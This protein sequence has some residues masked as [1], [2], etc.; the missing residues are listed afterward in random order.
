V[1]QRIVA[2]TFANHNWNGG[3]VMRAKLHS[4]GPGL[5]AR[6]AWL[7]VVALALGSGAAQGQGVGTGTIT[8]RLTDET[9][10]SMPGVTITV[11]SP[12]LQMKELTDVTSSDGGYRFVDMPIGVYSVKY[13]LT[14]FQSVVR[15]DVRLTA[16]FT[17]RLDA[18]LKVGALAET[19]TV[20][21]QSPVIDTS[22]TSG[23]V[24]FT[25]ETLENAPTSRAFA[26]VL[27][28][29]PGFRPSSVD[30][31]GSELSDMRAGVRNYGT[32][33]QLTPQLEG[34]NTRQG[35]NSAGFFY[36]Y[37]AVEE[38]QIQAVGN[39]AETALPGGAWNAIVKSGGDEFHGRYS[40]SGQNSKLQ[41][42]NVDDELRN[43]GV[44]PAG[45]GMRWYRD[46]SADLGGRIIR[47]RLWFY[48]ALHDQRSEENLIGFAQATGP[49]GV[50]FTAD[51]VPGYDRTI[52]HNQTVKSTFQATQTQKFVGFYQRSQKDSP[53]GQS[54]GPF[55]PFPATYNYEFPTHATKGE[56]TGTP[57][58]RVLFNLMGGR[59]WYD[60]NR[61]PQEGEDRPGNPR[62]FDRE[63]GR[64]LGPQHIQLRPRSRWQS[65]GSVSLFPEKLL[66]G[67]HSIK[68]GYQFFWEQ[69]GTAWLNMASG[70]Y[71]L[72]FD[73]VNNVSNQPAEFEAYNTPI[74][75]PVNK[76]TQYSFFVQDKWT[77]DRVTVN[78]GVRFDRYHAF[79]GEQVKEQGPFGNAG[80]FDAVDVLTWASFAPRL[81]IAWDLR[82]DGKTVAKATYGWFNHVMTEDFAAAYN[83][84]T[85]TTTNYRWR[86]LNGNR[87]YDPGEVNLD[88]NGADFISV[89]GATNN[90]LNP[91]LEQPVTHEVSLSLERELMP[92]FSA[93]MMYVYKRQN[94][95]YR[96]INVLRPYS[97]YT[98]P[99][100]RV[101]PGADGL[102]GTGDDGGPLTLF[103]YD[104]AFRGSAFV[105]N[106]PRNSPDDRD[107]NYD[108]IE[109]SVSK[110]MS[111]RW[112]LMATY[113]ATK[114]HRW[115][116]A[117]PQNPNEEINALDDTWD[118]YAKV[119]GTYQLPFGIYTSGFF[120]HLSGATLR[121][122]YVFRGIPNSSTITVPLEAFGGRR[123][124]SQNSL[125]WR[126][127]KRFEVGGQRKL[128]LNVDLFNALNA[129]TVLA[130]TVASGP[131]FGAI[132]E[133]TPPRIV[134]F[135]ATFSF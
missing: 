123:L 122:T 100:T 93:K 103:D 69:V 65:T 3:S 77:M 50:F 91:D 126:A 129:N 10:A 15:E 63:T 23:T 34:I 70:N 22:S 99:I 39:D 110:R 84:N 47:N 62:R 17:A 37:A 24:S 128:E 58:S 56:W 125:N 18:T 113:S 19:L 81:G 82:G 135:G 75:S 6:S 132:T 53:N 131:S 38:A 127:S 9:G 49:D 72:I 76:E 85:R 130:T 104:P 54:A 133:I 105:G 118:W 89:S 21:G 102:T 119:V 88:P 5:W 80:A 116:I 48:T 66:G 36:D 111:N 27:S 4:S 83:K 45:S 40:F 67:N 7:L 57:N 26:E 98:I 108:T 51:D 30:V 124:D 59:Q 28:M 114:N 1:N 74:L 107:D 78:A 112:E 90:I 44:D 95:L 13:E 134:R 92:N 79:V 2:P 101:D 64:S 121:R 94:N 16:G 8:G 109:T 68:T 31:G 43:Q 14:G 117:I 33:G 46:L 12:A 86:D 11:S 96:D 52:V 120:Q 115:Q 61:Y 29:A 97:A 25:K 32:A 42:S 60:A 35:S 20:S 87:D 71:R 73:R 41:S 106:S 55:E